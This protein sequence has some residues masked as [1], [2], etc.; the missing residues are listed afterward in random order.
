[1]PT[2]TYHWFCEQCEWPMSSAL[3]PRFYD[4][5]CAS[6]DPRTADERVAYRKSL[7]TVVNEDPKKPRDEPPRRRRKALSR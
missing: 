3:P 7:M 5:L 4:T 2:R 1:M 6:C